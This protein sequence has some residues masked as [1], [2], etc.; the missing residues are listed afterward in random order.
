VR[1]VDAIVLATAW[2]DYLEL[3]WEVARALV[4]RPAIFDGRNC[5]EGARLAQ[6]GFEYEG[7]GVRSLTAPRDLLE[8]AA[9]GAPL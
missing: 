8:Q 7:I 2:R 4:R 3:D 9:G 5:L 1:G 6:L